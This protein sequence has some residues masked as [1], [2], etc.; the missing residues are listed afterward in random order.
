MNQITRFL[1]EIDA[2]RGY[3]PAPT[4]TPTH[5]QIDRHITDA[6]VQLR[7]LLARHEFA[8]A[9]ALATEIEDFQR[10]ASRIGVNPNYRP[11]EPPAD[12]E[13]WRL[14]LPCWAEVLIHGPR[15]ERTFCVHAGATEAQALHAARGRYQPPFGGLHVERMV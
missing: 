5:S 1:D 11:P 2:R 10:A 8:A 6:A 7:D 12:S 4:P 3:T 9:E 15:A 13:T 14:T